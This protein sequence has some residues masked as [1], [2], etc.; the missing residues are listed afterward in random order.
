MTDPNGRVNGSAIDN[1]CEQVV[2]TMVPPAPM[3]S[4]AGPQFSTDQIKGL[5]AE[6]EVLLKVERSQVAERQRNNDNDPR[7]NF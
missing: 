4:S 5:I 6:L 7:Q 3:K 1:P 2:Q